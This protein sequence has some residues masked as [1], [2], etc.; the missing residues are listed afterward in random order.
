MTTTDDHTQQP[1]ALAMATNLARAVLGHAEH[2]AADPMDAYLRGTANRG[3]MGA[4]LGAD[5]A[6]ISIAGDVRRIADMMARVYTPRDDRA[7]E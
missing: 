2:L 1:D 6:L 5:L 3:V 4:Q 7:G